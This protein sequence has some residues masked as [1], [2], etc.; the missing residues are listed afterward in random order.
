MNGIIGAAMVACVLLSGCAFHRTVIN[1]P[2]R[3]LDVSSIEVGKTTWREVFQILGPPDVPLKDLRHF[4]YRSIDQ[5]LTIFRITFY[6]FLPWRW[7]DRQVVDEIMIELDENG[8]VSDLV[9]GTRGTV[10]PP[11]QGEAKRSP[12]A[13][14]TLSRR[15]P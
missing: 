13:T 10:R 12:S 8:I 7:Y 2:Q 11:L 6:L 4:H 5:R 15:S 1:E 3:N 14:R 9:R